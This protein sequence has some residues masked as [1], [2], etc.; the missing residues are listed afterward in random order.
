MVEA[1]HG[2]LWSWMIKFKDSIFGMLF[3]VRL[4]F[5]AILFHDEVT[6]ISVSTFL[7]S[8]IFMLLFPRILLSKGSNDKYFWNW[9]VYIMY[10]NEGLCILIW[11]WLEFC[12]MRDSDIRS[13]SFL[14]LN[15]RRMGGELLLAHASMITNFSWPLTGSYFS[16][17][18]MNGSILY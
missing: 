8:W 17:I 11:K 14:S 18:Q 13:A 1:W 9:L 12:T 2:E 5:F 4:D 3:E 7:A 10:N 16:W 6:C 15:P